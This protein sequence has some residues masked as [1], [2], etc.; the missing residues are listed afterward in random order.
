MEII[1]RSY[2][3]LLIGH[4]TLISQPLLTGIALHVNDIPLLTGNQI[5]FASPYLQ[6][7][8]FR[9]PQMKLVMQMLGLMNQQCT[10][11]YKLYTMTKAYQDKFEERHI[12]KAYCGCH[13]P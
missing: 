13:S 6:G 3:S 10:Y 9:A 5:N 8:Q 11:C 2:H 7:T 12:A 4:L 1:C